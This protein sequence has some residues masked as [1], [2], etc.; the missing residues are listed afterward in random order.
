MHPV[1]LGVSFAV[2]VPMGSHWPLITRCFHKIWIRCIFQHFTRNGQLCQ[3]SVYPSYLTYL[4]AE[5][6]SNASL[7]TGAGHL[8]ASQRLEQ[9]TLSYLSLAGLFL[10]KLILS[11]KQHMCFVKQKSKPEVV[12][13]CFISFKKSQWRLR[14][15]HR[16]VR[17]PQNHAVTEAGK[18]PWDH[19]AQP[20]TFPPTL[21]TN[22]APQCHIPM[23]PDHHHG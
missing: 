21:P 19:P 2:V 17:L 6:L 13:H 8:L 20:S 18:T 23:A 16:Q 12:L 11:C 4:A 15:K 22:C 9:S 7:T 3:V 10:E 5:Q 1:E 14:G